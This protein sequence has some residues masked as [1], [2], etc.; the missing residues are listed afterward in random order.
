MRLDFLRPLYEHPGPYVSVYLDTGRDSEKAADEVRLRWRAA[1]EELAAEGVKADVL[2]DVEE[3]VTSADAAAPGRAVFAHG[4]GIAYTEPLPAAPRRPIARAGPLPHVTPLLA[5]RAGHVPHLVVL[6]D[7]RGARVMGVTAAGEQDVAETGEDDRPVQKTGRGGL[8]A[9][10]YDRIAEGV[11]ER[12]AG[13]TAAEVERRARRL[14]AEVVVVGGDPQTRSMLLE[15]LGPEVRDK[16]VVAEHAARSPG[17]SSESWEER[18]DSALTAWSRGRT[19]DAVDRFQRRRGAD[20]TT[21]G[22]APTARRL[23]EGRVAE[24]LLVDRPEANG[25]LWI[26][27][28]PQQVAADVGELRLEGVSEPERERADDALVRGACATG[29]ELIFVGPDDGT[30]DDVAAV[31]R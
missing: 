13:Q 27:P 10:R 9:P 17:A 22:I 30:G 12:N 23:R 14:G 29:A 15:R 2:D 8:S 1:R 18:L 26:G 16:V 28:E 20:G 21:E 5:Q 6:A 7:H 3:L 4:D 11:W 25:R 19:E 24:L 31:L